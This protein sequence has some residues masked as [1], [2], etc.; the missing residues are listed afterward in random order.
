MIIEEEISLLIY[1]LDVSKSNCKTFNIVSFYNSRSEEID[2]NDYRFSIFPQK[3]AKK[4]ERK[5]VS[6]H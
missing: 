3:S 2:I 4:K 1:K 6:N 5:Q